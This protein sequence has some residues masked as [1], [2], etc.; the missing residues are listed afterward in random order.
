M[1]EYLIIY[2]STDGH[3]KTICET[4]KN[5]LKNKELVKIVSLKEAFASDLSK[6]N[7]II[8]GASIRYGRHIKDASNFIKKNKK[9]LDLK[10]TAF[11]SVNVVAR[12]SEKSLPNNNPYLLK[13]LN[14]TKWK[15]NKVGVFAGKVDYPKYNI[16]NKNV[17]RLIMMMTKGP[18]NVNNSYEFTNWENVKKFA[19]ELENL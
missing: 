12:K 14:K 1:F 16:I 18:T 2:S 17:I 6:F 13:F 15:P 7:K 4:I 10:K 8:L 19:E 9:I 3:T 11:F 5:H